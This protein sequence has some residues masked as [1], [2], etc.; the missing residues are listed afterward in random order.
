MGFLQHL[1]GWIGCAKQS[2]AV[3]RVSSSAS[4]RRDRT[5][6]VW[7]R[8]LR[9]RNGSNDSNA[10]WVLC[11]VSCIRRWSRR[12]RLTRSMSNLLE[13]Q[14]QLCSVQ[15]S[16]LAGGW[17]HNDTCVPYS[18]TAVVE[19]F[20]YSDLPALAGH[21]SIWCR[22]LPMQ[23]T[24]WF[25][26]AVQTAPCIQYYSSTVHLLDR[27]ICGL[28]RRMKKRARAKHS[29]SRTLAPCTHLGK[30]RP[31]LARFSCGSKARASLDWM[32]AQY[33]TDCT[34]ITILASLPLT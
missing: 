3:D 9:W 19:F 28:T 22:A 26:V 13:S 8:A 17:G 7:Y 6:F 1:Y 5:C 16:R 27:L 24:A 18:L 11:H 25:L 30:A 34:P 23:T 20:G 4:S 14:L 31:R 29:P 33:V 15:Y 2:H 32:S 10:G 12:R 21:L